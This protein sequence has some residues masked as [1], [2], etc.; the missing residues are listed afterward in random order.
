MRVSAYACTQWLSGV[1]ILQVVLLREA[2]EE[3][4]SSFAR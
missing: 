2:Q 1:L 4:T 3:G